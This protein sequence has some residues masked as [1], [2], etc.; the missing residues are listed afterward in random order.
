MRAI[1]ESHLFMARPVR[2]EGV[3][4][5]VHRH[6]DKQL[7]PMQWAVVLALDAA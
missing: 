3:V 5:I 6:A 2:E 7:C 4:L 1:D